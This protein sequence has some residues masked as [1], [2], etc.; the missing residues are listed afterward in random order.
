M[1]AVSCVEKPRSL[2]AHAH[3]VPASCS[4][5]GHRQ[6]LQCLQQPWLQLHLQRPMAQLS[7]SEQRSPSQPDT[8]EGPLFISLCTPAASPAPAP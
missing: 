1:D 4:H 2:T 3:R 8:R 7:V 6:T 5:L